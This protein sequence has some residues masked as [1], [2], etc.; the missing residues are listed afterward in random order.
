MVN[1]NSERPAPPL[2]S[3]VRPK[4]RGRLGK[5]AAILLLFL[6][7]L[8]VGR[9]V[10][11]AK[12]LAQTPLQFVA[13]KEGER[14]LVFPTFWEAWDILHEDFIGEVNDKN[15]FYGA[16]SGL[17]N[18]SG[19]PYTVFSDPQETK[20]FEEN[21]EGSFSGVGVEIGIRDGAVTVIAPLDGSP[22]AVAGVREEDIV[23]AIDDKPIRPE[24][25]L[26]DVVNRIRGPKGTSVKLTVLHKDETAPDEITIVRD[27]IH[28]ESVKMT[29]EDGVAHMEIS[30]FNGDTPQLF[31]E[32]ARE[33]ARAQVKGV[34]LDVRNNPGGFLEGAVK[35]AGVFLEPNT[36]VVSEKG[37]QEKEYRSKGQPVLPGMPV[38][39][40]INGGSAS[41]AEI[42]AGALQ[43]ERGARLVGQKTFGKGSVQEF[44]KLTD[45][46]SIRVTVAKWFTPKGHS[47][48]EQGIEPDLVVEGNRDT[49]EDEQLN[50]AREELQTL[51]KI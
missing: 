13:V 45:G 34:I 31:T 25:N 28:I 20:Q 17:V 1:G 11:P 36:R 5:L 37:D 33:A 21:I 29:I 30:S 23:A 43:D 9:Y 48:D 24:E 7:G 50:R 38:V 51:V 42:V 41:A 49:P 2:A 10:V 19:D 35:I 16:V 27:T 22:A 32:A 18:A 40:L 47:I 15:L 46:S 26:D 12:E 8:F 44:K 3:E 6:A 4:K 14:E 39:V